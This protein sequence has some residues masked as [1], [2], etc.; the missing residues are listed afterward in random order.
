MWDAHYVQGYINLVETDIQNITRD[1]LDV[2][3]G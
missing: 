1:I 2:F 3:W